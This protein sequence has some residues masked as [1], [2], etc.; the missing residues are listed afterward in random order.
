MAVR[1]APTA[2]GRSDARGCHLP[3]RPQLGRRRELAESDRSAPELSAP[4][5]GASWHPLPDAEIVDGQVSW[6]FSRRALGKYRLVEGYQAPLRL[7]NAIIQ[8][9]NIHFDIGVPAWMRSSA[10]NA[11]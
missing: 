4:L 2:I 10:L 8:L 6:P 3:R 9:P 1:V 7:G 11:A 5:L